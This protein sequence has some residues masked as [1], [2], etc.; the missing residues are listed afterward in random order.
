[1]LLRRLKKDVLTELPPKRRQIIELPDDSP[2]A[3]AALRLEAEVEAK[4]GAQVA[5]LRAAV[6]AASDDP[7]AYRAAVLALRDAQSIAF[8]EMSRIRHAT[9]IAKAPMVAEHIREVVEAGGK[10][11][12]MAHHKDVVEHLHNALADLGV[13]LLTG[14]TPVAKRQQAVDA[15]QGDDKVRVFIGNILA[16]GVGITLTAS[17]HVIFAEL[18]WTPGN[19]SQAEDRAY[20]IGQR[21]AVLVQHLVLEGSI[22][23]KM[24]VTVLEKQQVIDAAL[25]VIE[26]G[27]DRE[28][29]IAAVQAELDA[30]SSDAVAAAKEKAAQQAAAQV[31]AD[32]AALEAQEAK[33]LRAAERAADA[34]QLAKEMAAARG[35]R[36][37]ASIASAAANIGAADVPTMEA[38]AAIHLSL[39]LLADLDQDGA[40][41]VNGAGYSK[42]DSYHGHYLA[43]LPVLSD[44]DAIVGC[45]LV[46]RYQRQL[47]EG[48]VAKAIG[49][50]MQVRATKVERVPEV[51]AV[52]PE[53]LEQQPDKLAGLPVTL[54][55]EFLA[56]MDIAANDDVEVAP[57]PSLVTNPDLSSPTPAAAWELVHGQGVLAQNAAWQLGITLPRML[58]LLGE[59]KPHAEAETAAADQGNEPVEFTR[60]RGRPPKGGTTLTQVERN[61]R[62]RASK[63]VVPV[64]MSGAVAERLRSMRD[65]N[66]MT[67]SE[68]LAAA[69]DALEQA[70]RVKAA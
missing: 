31:A 15:F 60:G 22:D 56:S 68:L 30:A 28:A 8:T 23:A 17:A 39:Q 9:A 20:R 2:A 69:L 21:N 7:A 33:R 14:D 42:V 29:R 41:E 46:R 36:L 52:E 70:Q 11:I 26:D 50:P 13:V 37:A 66:G 4:T 6:A 3:R 24:A 51:V 1:M 49:E 62:W 65:A 48:L 38:T 25:D 61:K 44:V 10:V 47:T 57:A 34:I 32:Q 58:A 18:D 43:R 55:T 53:T 5:R 59:H 67:T 35:S 54:V 40:S 19:L 12:V 16:A 63:A 45:E 27:A 64:E